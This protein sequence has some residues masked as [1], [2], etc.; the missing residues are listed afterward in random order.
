MK[1]AEVS[2]E[3]EKSFIFACLRAFVNKDTSSQQAALEAFLPNLDWKSIVGIAEIHRIL[4]FLALVLQRTKALR[5]LSADVQEQ[6]RENLQSAALENLVKTA[7]F[8]KINR[9]FERQGIPVIPLKGI[10]LTHLIYQEDGVRRMRD[11][12]I[13]VRETDLEKTKE[14][15]REQE[16]KLRE[17]QNR[18][19]M[20]LWN[21][22]LGRSNYVK[23]DL[24]IDVQWSP[25]FLVNGQ[26]VEWD[27]TKAWRNASPCSFFGTNVYMLSPLDQA[28]YLLLQIANDSEVGTLLLIQLLDL[29]LVMKRYPMRADSILSCGLTSVS[30]HSREKLVDLLQ[31]IQERFLEQK[32]LEECSLKTRKLLESIFER[33]PSLRCLLSGS[34]LLKSLRSPFDKFLFLSGYFFPSKSYLQVKQGVTAINPVRDLQRIS[35][36]VKLFSRHLEHWG[37]LIL[38]ALKIPAFFLVRKWTLLSQG[39]R[40]E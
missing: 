33:D 11:I 38:K 1:H 32:V 36:G 15:L 31:A 3:K 4:P 17:G 24:D 6:M 29:A 21:P 12:D 18:W 10:A 20:E 9:F 5:K 35:N 27:Y 39:Q 16:F 8:Q 26:W 22:I 34:F 37:R 28:Q 23:E 40:E 19:Q 13:L 14:L 30:P 2:S 25:R 7:E